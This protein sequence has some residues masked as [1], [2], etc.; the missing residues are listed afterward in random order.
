LEKKMYLDADLGQVV[1]A[2]GLGEFL[3]VGEDALGDVGV[4][5][6]GLEHLVDVLL[7]AGAPGEHLVWEA[8]DLEALAV[9]AQP[10]HSHV[11]EALLPHRLHQRPRHIQRRRRTLPV[12]SGARGRRG[13]LNPR[14][15]AG[16][17]SWKFLARRRRER[18]GRRVG[19]GFD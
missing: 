13:D 3:G 14:Q 19:D 1:G 5:G 11:G 8:G 12:T 2:E 9:L 18:G 17:G 6:V 7:D 4:D 10:H 15:A 16:L